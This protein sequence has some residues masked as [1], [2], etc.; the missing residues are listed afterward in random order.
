MFKVKGEKL[1][2]EISE[3]AREVRWSAE[4]LPLAA[5]PH[6]DF[7]RLHLEAGR[8]KDLTVCSS[9]QTGI[10]TG[11]EN[12]IEICY[13]S[14]TAK[15]NKEYRIR[16]TVTVKSDGKLIEFFAAVEN[17]DDVRIDEVQAPFIDLAAV[18]DTDRT[19]DTLYLPEGLGSRIENVWKW[20]E[21]NHTEYMSADYNEIW[22]AYTYPAPMSMAWFGIESGGHFLYLGRHDETFRNYAMSIGGAPRNTDPRLIL[23]NT[24]YPAAVKGERIECGHSFISLAEGG[25][26][27][28]CNIYGKWARDNWYHAPKVPEWIQNMTGWQRIIMKPQYG[29]IFFRYDDLPRLYREGAQY[30]LDTLMV[31]GWWKGGFDNGYPLYEPDEEMGGAQK[32][33]EAID[34]IQSMGGRV[35][36]YNNGAI[37]DV[38]GD[39]YKETGHKISKKNIDNVEYHEFY[40]FSNNGTLLR[41]FGYKTFVSACNAT[42]E[43]KNKLIENAKIKLSFHPDALFFDQMGGSNPLPCFD[44]THKHKN[45]CD[46][47]AQYKIENIK[48]LNALLSGDMGIGTEIVVDAFTPYF[49]Y[50]HGMW[51]ECY[52]E[53]CFPQ[54]YRTVFPETILTNRRIHDNKK[55]FRKHLNF[56]FVNGLR[57]DVSIFRGRVGGIAMLPD[58]A[59]HVK[60]LLELKEHYRGYFYE[61]S[62]EGPEETIPFGGGIWANRFRS[63]QGGLLTVLW[64]E[65]DEAKQVDFYGET[66]TLQ[67]NE[68]LCKER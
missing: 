22:A 56:A 53:H 32:L 28:G 16:L 27:N 64:N 36:L 40:G 49:H 9:E 66:I 52:K 34:E 1:I 31:F 67:P 8:R 42:D 6:S 5:S 24:H 26:K 62:F 44:S 63:A 65:T 19:K 68:I 45:R 2:F 25:W 51:G 30:G 61:G 55:G 58:Y 48:E 23:S 4:G 38:A 13:P 7:W 12:R 41:L 33:R 17:E 20:T 37:I 3:D 46:A 39:F 10:V 54:L 21:G 29:E 57:F 43:W 35:I 47:E 14:L 60:Y 15:D 50:Y 18:A 11:T 59:E